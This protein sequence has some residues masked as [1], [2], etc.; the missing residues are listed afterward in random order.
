MPYETWIQEVFITKSRIKK[1]KCYRRPNAIKTFLID[2]FINY[3]GVTDNN[4]FGELR[5]RCR[6]IIWLIFTRSYRTATYP[7]PSWIF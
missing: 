5:H 4:E 2:F 3:D 1:N 6:R 7:V